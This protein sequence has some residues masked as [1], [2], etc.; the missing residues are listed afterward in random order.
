VYFN[1]HRLLTALKQLKKSISRRST[2]PILKGVLIEPGTGYLTSTNLDSLQMAQVTH[3]W[4]AGPN[5]VAPLNDL[6]KAILP[7]FPY[8]RFEV[9]DPVD[10]DNG[11]TQ[12]RF[13]VVQATHRVTLDYWDSDDYPQPPNKSAEYVGHRFSADS[14]NG[15]RQV[16]LPCAAI[17]DARPNLAGAEFSSDNNTLSVVCADGFRIGVGQFPTSPHLD[18]ESVLI[19]AQPL[20]KI[21]PSKVEVMFASLWN[22]RAYAAFGWTDRKTDMQ[23]TLT[24]RT[25]DAAFPDWEQ[26]RPQDRAAG[27]RIDT[28]VIDLANKVPTDEYRVL[29]F[30][31][32]GAFLKLGGG[33][34]A[35][36]PG[37]CTLEG[38]LPYAAFNPEYLKDAKYLAD[39]HGQINFVTIDANSW[40]KVFEAQ[41][42][43]PIGDDGWYISLIMPMK[44]LGR[45]V[46]EKEAA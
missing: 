21:I 29:N 23:L 42:K 6:I 22:D 20:F 9:H 44:F 37:V 2:L 45:P 35:E 28:S 18:L 24:L 33:R 11:H 40:E 1:T 41:G 16:V 5:F 17:G 32:E 15:L 7:D 46:Q 34:V 10:L 31:D 38:G 25:I 14:W 13:D 27:L 36:W 43:G 3:E 26:M 8:V 19:P 4:Q 30:D 39:I 12:R